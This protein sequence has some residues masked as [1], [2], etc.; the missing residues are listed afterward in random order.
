MDYLNLA[1][2]ALVLIWWL[3]RSYRLY[4]TFAVS[5]QNARALLFLGMG[6]VGIIAFG[7]QYFYR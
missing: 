5:P 2:F 7:I 3:Q 6:W 4:K 1:A